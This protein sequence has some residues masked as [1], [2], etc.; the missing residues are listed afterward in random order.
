MILFL[1]EIMIE[2]Q[3]MRIEILL[4]AQIFIWQQAKKIKET[5]VR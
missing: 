3:I 4:L 5:H 1:T 2:I